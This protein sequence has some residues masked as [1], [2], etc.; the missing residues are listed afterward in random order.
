[1]EILNSTE[2][3]INGVCLILGFF[4]GV[5]LGH[6]MVIH[7]ATQ[8][9]KLNKTKTVLLTF[10]NSPSEYF[11]KS[12]EYIFPRAYSYKLIENLDVDYLIETD[13]SDWVNVSA[14]NYLDEIVR[15]F[16]PISI[17]TGFN[18]TFGKNKQG[19]SKYLSEN[20]KKYNYKYLESNAY[21][22]DGEVVSSTLIKD[23]IHFG[24]I[25]KANKLLSCP[26]TITSKVTEG[27]KLARE[28]GYPTA[29]MNYPQNIVKLPYGVYK[30]EVYGKMAILNWG[31]KPTIGEKNEVLEFHILGFED[32]L[33]GKTV[34]VNILE[35]IRDEKKFSNLDELK[36]QI[37][38]DIEKCSE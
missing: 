34:S 21:I 26:F 36:K 13:F 6:Q 17:S 29:N 27:M 37:A 2:I 10:K 20:S 9:A 35:K 8:M 4:D 31:V 23:C 24:N 16:E 11:N 18:Y 5:H 33:Y 25:E 28:L 22:I 32:N 14:I 7:S 19:N 30:A 15:K 3:N 1:M 38:K 12:C